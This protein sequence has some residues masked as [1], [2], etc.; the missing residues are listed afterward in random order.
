VKQEKMI[1]NKKSERNKQNTI[2]ES[3]GRNQTRRCMERDK[4]EGKFGHQK[5]W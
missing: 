2:K 1:K 4:G 5:R 3:L